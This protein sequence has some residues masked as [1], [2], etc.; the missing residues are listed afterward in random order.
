LRDTL[1]NNVITTPV[2]R[3]EKT[4]VRVAERLQ[5][6][7]LT[8]K[9]AAGSRLPPERLLCQQLGVSRTVLREA[10]KLLSARGLVEEV[11]GRGTHV[12]QPNLNTV[13]KLLEICLSWHAQAFLE[14]L[15]EL[16]RLIEVEIAGLAA[17][18]ATETDLSRLRRNLQEMEAVVDGNIKRFTKLD[19]AFHLGLAKATH[20]ELFLILFEAI[21]N[22]M[23]ERWE[24][25]YWDPE[26]RRHG[27]QF[28]K[29]ILAEIERKDPDAARRAVRRNIQA[30]KHDV[31]TH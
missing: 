21:A 12:S 1:A 11:T 30:F 17:V 31:L 9:L 28:H 16:R 8:K 24:K 4:Y 15:V 22:A 19:L 18:H 3:P 29:K 26:V 7:I 20:N 10:L 5:V 25:M 23:V 2:A 6:L 14:N 13:K 27:V